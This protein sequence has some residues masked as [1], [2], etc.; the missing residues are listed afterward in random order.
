MDLENQKENESQHAEEQVA[1]LAKVNPYPV[2]REHWVARHPTEFTLKEKM[3]AGSGG[4]FAVR[5]HV[6]KTMFLTRKGA[7]GKRT[8]LD[9]WNHVIAQIETPAATLHKSRRVVDC[10]GQLLFTAKTKKM[11]VHGRSPELFIYLNDGDRI[12]DFEVVEDGGERRVRLQRIKTSELIARISPKGSRTLDFQCSDGFYSVYVAGG[13]DL[14]F[15]A[16]VAI[17]MDDVFWN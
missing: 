1:S 12:P 6:G 11:V 3:F 14:A 9:S 10:D 17:I 4:S 16:L 2:V 5:D 8:L 13:G 7:L 15:A